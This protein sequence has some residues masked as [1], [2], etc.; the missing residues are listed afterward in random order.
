MITSGAQ[1]PLVPIVLL[2]ATCPLS[3]IPALA[4]FYGVP[5]DTLEVIREE[6][7]STVSKRIKVTF[8]I[9]DTDEMALKCL[10]SYLGRQVDL[11]DPSVRTLVLVPTTALGK[12]AFEAIAKRFEGLTK[13]EN[14]L[15]VSS[16]SSPHEIETAMKMAKVIV[17]TPVLLFAANI[18]DLIFVFSMFTSHS[19]E[20]VIQGLGR[21][22]RGDEEAE[23]VFIFSKRAHASLF[24]DIGTRKWGLEVA[25]PLLWARGQSLDVALQLLFTPLG[26]TSI[27]QRKDCRRVVLNEIL[28]CAPSTSFKPCQPYEALCDICLAVGN[29]KSKQ[30]RMPEEEISDDDE[31]FATMDLSAFEGTDE[32]AEPQEHV[33]VNQEKALILSELLFKNVRSP[34]ICFLCGMPAC[35]GVRGSC[36]KV[37]IGWAKYAT[38]RSAIICYRCG[39]EHLFDKCTFSDVIV[40][41]GQHR[42]AYCL[43][44]QTE[45]G[46]CSFHISPTYILNH[47]QNNVCK[48]LGSR[49]KKAIALFFRSK[50]L[51]DSFRTARSTDF[52]TTATFSIPLAETSTFAW[53]LYQEWLFAPCVHRGGVLNVDV[54]LGWMHESL[55]VPP[56]RLSV[57]LGEIRRTIEDQT[58][59]DEESDGEGEE[60]LEEM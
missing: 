10:L 22:G 1:R 35:N 37:C 43:L 27:V 20:N 23:F 48:A 26:V 57:L 39:G 50:L 21:V 59:E 24:G 41:L 60:F 56:Q 55:S 12:F 34:N 36:G 16:A 38:N 6:V 4:D 3:A 45:L 9:V 18:Q 31:I 53:G 17:S 30:P 54:L 44:A 8:E 7:I 33:D 49:N 32:Q 15:L 14:L 52:S 25:K 51:Q 42:C 47:P 5:P 28:N 29:V 58:E 40:P 13:G 11:L 46:G 19:V 2:T